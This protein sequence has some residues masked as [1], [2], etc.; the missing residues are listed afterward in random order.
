MMIVCTCDICGRV[1]DTWSTLN[2]NFRGDTWKREVCNDCYKG[3][4]DKINT[5]IDSITV[6]NPEEKVND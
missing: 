2:I 1:V 5:F 6:T 3:T 4:K